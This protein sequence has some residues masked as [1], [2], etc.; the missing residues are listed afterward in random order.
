MDV[1]DP[2]PRYSL[3]EA[4]ELLKLV[5]VIAAEMVERRGERHVLARRR[6]HMEAAARPERMRDAL[7]RLDA[8]IWE[9]DEALRT[10]TKELLDLGLTVLRPQPLTLHIPGRSLEAT[11]EGVDRE[12]VFC[13]QE[14][15]GDL[16]FGHP[17]GEE[18]D[19]RRPLRV[20]KGA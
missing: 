13:W 15:E 18:E 20:A 7:A 8:R 2:Q 3:T 4:N 1:V 5:R 16:E 19:H 17:L 11:G 6:E 9:H 12:V 10:C 14:G